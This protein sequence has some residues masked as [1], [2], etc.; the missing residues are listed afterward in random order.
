MRPRNMPNSLFLTTLV[1]F[2]N[3][4]AL[5]KYP[6]YGK[7]VPQDQRQE[8]N[9][10]LLYLINNGK[11]EEY[12]ISGADIYN[13]YT[14]DGGLHGLNR[15]DYESYAKYS[16][17]KKEMENGQFFTPPSLCRLVAESLVACNI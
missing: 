10:K 14:G 8:F 6:F 15:Q 9:D 1:A 16:E 2:I 13:L 11:T 4:G 7:T 12:E 17:A 5:V 3:G